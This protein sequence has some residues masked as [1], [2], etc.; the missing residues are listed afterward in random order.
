MIVRGI[1]ARAR[2]FCS[3]SDLAELLGV[4]SARLIQALH[5][6]DCSPVTDAQDGESV[7]PGSWPKGMGRLWRE[8][9]RP[10]VIGL[11]HRP[12]CGDCIPDSR[13]GCD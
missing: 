7:S 4:D 11:S 1:V 6:G 12:G 8:S 5:E 3:L 13:N 9:T 10:A 2:R